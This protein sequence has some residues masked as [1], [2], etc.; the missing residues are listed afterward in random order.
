MY[1]SGDSLKKRYAAITTWPEEDRP[2]EKLLRCGEQTLSDSELLAILLRTGVRGQSAVDLA[3]KILCELGVFRRMSAADISQWRRI[4]GL[5]PAKIAQIKAALEIGRRC[6]A[7]RCNESHPK[8]TCSGDAAN[9]LMPRLR[10][11][12]KEVF[13][14]ILLNTQNRVIRLEDGEEGTVNQAYPIIREIF[15]KAL[16][17]NAACMICVHNHPGGNPAPSPEDKEMTKELTQAGRILLVG[18][19]DHII[20]GKNRYFSFA[21]EGLM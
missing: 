6:A 4:R 11:L 14:I 16:R 15:Q 2:R 19:L 1:T 17:H 10:D 21:D 9:M 18:V 7:D 5:G 13:K 12:E 8:I 3:R 20:I